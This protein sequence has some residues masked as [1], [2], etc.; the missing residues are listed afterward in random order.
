MRSSIFIW[1][2]LLLIGSLAISQG[3]PNDNEDS[4]ENELNARTNSLIESSESSEFKR[5]EWFNRRSSSCTSAC[6]PSCQSDELCLASGVC[7]C[8][9]GRGNSPCPTQHR[10]V[11]APSDTAGVKPVVS[12]T[13]GEGTKKFST[14]KPSSLGFSTNY[15]QAFKSQVNDGF[16]AIVNEVPQDFGSW[17]GGGL[18]HTKGCDAG[19]SKGYMMLVNAKLAKGGEILHINANNLCLGLGYEFHF[20]VANINKKGTNIQEPEIQIDIRSGT[21]SGHKIA[22]SYAGPVAEQSKLTWVKYGV[23]FV[24]TS[25]SVVASLTSTAPGGTGNDFVL[26]DITLVSCSPNNNGVCRS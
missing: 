23:S 14:A 19:S 7:V 15:P 25:S 3:Y 24:A 26:D 16:F 2:G 6:R 21:G 5:G 17:L 1:A 18:D 11:C 20:Y 12:V 8:P 9:G 13:F 22:S 4:D 10:H